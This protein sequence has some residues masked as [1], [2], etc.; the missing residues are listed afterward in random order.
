MRIRLVGAELFQADGQ[1]D[2]TKLIFA[3]RNFVNKP[4]ESLYINKPLRFAVAFVLNC[5]GWN[6]LTSSETHS[7]SYS[8]PYGDASFGVK[9]PG[10]EV[11]HSF[12][13]NAEIK[14]VCRYNPPPTHTRRP[15]SM[16]CTGVCLLAIYYS[17]I[18]HG[19]MWKINS[20][21][22]LFIHLSFFLSFMHSL[23]L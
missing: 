18:S 11:G 19:V 12:P 16:S 9:L 22:Y 21:L 20:I 6:L 13:C 17:V 15:T 14:N 5:L 3:F 7:L 8:L 1:M 2:V 10:P 23:C 4:N